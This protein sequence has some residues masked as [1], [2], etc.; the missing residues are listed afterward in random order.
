MQLPHNRSH[1]PSDYQILLGY[2]QLQHP[3]E[4]SLCMTVNRIIVHSDFNK[5]YFMGSDIALLQL[6][7]SVNFTSHVLPSC[8]PGPN[9]ELPSHTSCWITG[10][11]IVTE[12]G[13]QA[14]Q[15]RKGSLRRGV[16]WPL[17]ALPALT[18]CLLKLQVAF[19]PGS[20]NLS[21]SNFWNQELGVLG[22]EPFRIPP[23]SQ[24]LPGSGPFRAPS[25]KHLELPLPWKV[26]GAAVRK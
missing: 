23:D 10:W 16:Q 1:E 2:H 11:G 3:T 8:L 9:A 22:S 6:H 19:I 20:N 4:H 12:Q 7:L 25:S 14:G 26:S 18:A 21:I 5:P 13:A 24:V 17:W 15:M